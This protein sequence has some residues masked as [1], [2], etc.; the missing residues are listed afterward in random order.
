MLVQFRVFYLTQSLARDDHDVQAGKQLLVQTKGIAHQALEAVAL[1]GELDTLLADYQAKAWVI[2]AV[3]ASKDQQVF[4]W[5]LAGWGVEDRF[6]MSGCKQSLFP[7][8][9][10]THHLCRKIK[11]PDAYGLW[12]DDATEQR[13]RSW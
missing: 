10:L 12:H 8:E 9:V 13:G 6:E 4:P 7:T 5:N 3:L 2:E 11:W 1:N